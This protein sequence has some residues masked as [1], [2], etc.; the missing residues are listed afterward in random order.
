MKVFL[1]YPSEHEEAAR[2]IKDFVRAVGLDCWFDKDSILPGMDWE[3]ERGRAQ[4][5]A[6]LF[7]LVCASQTT[8]RDGVYQREINQALRQLDDRRLGAIYILPVR[9]ED[10]ALPPEIA[11]FQ[12]VDYFEPNW[13]QRLAGSLSRAASDRG[14]AIPLMLQVAATA[15]DEGGVTMRELKEE[16]PRWDLEASWPH[17]ELPGEYWRFVNAVILREAMGGFYETRRRMAEWVNDGHSS[18][19]MHVTEFHRRDQLV[20]L[21]LGHFEYYSGAAHPNHGVRS[22]NILG[23]DAGVVPIDE[24]FDYSPDALTFLNDYVTLDL[25]RQYLGSS[26]SLDITHYQNTY[27]WELYRQYSFNEAGMRLN[28]SAYSGLPHVLGYHEVY[29][30]WENVGHLLAAVPKMILLPDPAGDRV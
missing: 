5:E 21:T 11:R 12:Y 9:L 16:R 22:I 14:E 10:S 18:W 27:G 24:L 1:S 7:L 3:R 15:P 20:S 26:D 19:E 4:T 25:E 30:P 23:E 8:Q 2:E 28:L 13:R 17:Y 6:D 29:M